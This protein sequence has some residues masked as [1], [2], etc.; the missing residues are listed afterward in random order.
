MKKRLNTIEQFSTFLLVTDIDRLTTR[1]EFEVK[2][3]QNVEQLIK[4][5]KVDSESLAYNFLTD[6]LAKPTN[7]EKKHLI[8]YLQEVCFWAAKKV[9]DRLASIL[10]SL[11]QGEYFLLANEI[12]CQPHQLLA[13]YN[14]NYGKKISQYAQLRLESKIADSAYATVGWKLCSD[15][16]LLKKISKI[17][18]RKS[19]AQI[20]GLSGLKLEEYLLVWQCF[21][22]NYASNSPQKNRNLSTPNQ[23][24]FKQMNE[25]FNLLANNLFNSTTTITETQFEERLNSCSQWARKY[26]NPQTFAATENF[27]LSPVGSDISYLEVREKKENLEQVN[28]ALE[29]SF[30]KL[31]KEQKT[32]LYLWLG[33]NLSQQEIVNIF[34]KIYPDF[35]KKQY[36]L[37][38]QINQIRKVLIDTLIENKFPEKKKFTSQEFKELKNPL[39]QFLNESVHSRMFQFCRQALAVI[40]NSDFEEVKGYYV[41][42][43]SE[44]SDLIQKIETQMQASLQLQLESIFEF[45]LSNYPAIN[46]GLKQVIE[47]FLLEEA[48]K[49]Y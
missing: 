39:E 43:L 6:L 23:N 29:A 20:G 41:Q 10:S 40:D 13:R 11:K 18:M 45:S 37:S 42:L 31:T 32:I 3:K 16:G 24:Q 21:R 15:W 17:K 36:Q 34:E 14:P 28:Q 19:L 49:L 26:T 25:Q 38:R 27:D 48:N 1:W 4:D 9:Y 35:I 2:L 46:R 22:D 12:V 44:K 30:E 5:K 33:L 47:D 7:L 8:A